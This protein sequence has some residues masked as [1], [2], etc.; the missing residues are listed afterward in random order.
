MYSA[1]LYIT[2]YAAT[3]TIAD[4]DHKKSLS[5]NKATGK[6]RQTAILF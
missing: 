4:S 3:V 6:P 2:A 1:S 5:R